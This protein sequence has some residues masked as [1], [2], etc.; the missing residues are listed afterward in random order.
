MSSKRNG[1]I[2]LVYWTP[3]LKFAHMSHCHSGQTL[4]SIIYIYKRNWLF[5][6][7]CPCQSSAI[8]L[9]SVTNVARHV[10]HCASLG[11]QATLH[12]QSASIMYYFGLIEGHY[13]WN[14]YTCKENFKMRSPN[15]VNDTTCGLRSMG[16]QEGLIIYVHDLQMYFQCLGLLARDLQSL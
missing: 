7:Y 16:L 2:C 11:V 5:G 4:P 12:E 14:T 1:F 3:Y 10:W 9:S 6:R 13:I 15:V 8:V